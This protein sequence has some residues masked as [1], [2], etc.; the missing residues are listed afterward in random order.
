MRWT[1]MNFFGFVCLMLRRQY[2]YSVRA[3]PAFQDW[4]ASAFVIADALSNNL[5]DFSLCY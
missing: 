5:R 3:P 1:K 4:E 2:Y